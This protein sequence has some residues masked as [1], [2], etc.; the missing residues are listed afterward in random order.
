MKKRKRNADTGLG[1]KCKSK[2]FRIIGATRDMPVNGN[3]DSVYLHYCR[4]TMCNIYI[5]M[6]QIRKFQC[7]C[8]GFKVR[9]NARNSYPTASLQKI[10]RY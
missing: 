10:V 2:C 3:Q 7:P 6:E 5:P 4:C 8:C 9:T 1:Y